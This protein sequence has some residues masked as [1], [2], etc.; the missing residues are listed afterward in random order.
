RVLKRDDIR[1]ALALCYNISFTLSYKIIQMGRNF[2]NGQRSISCARKSASRSTSVRL[3]RSPVVLEVFALVLSLLLLAS[4]G[5]ALS[6]SHSDLHL[7]PDCDLC[8]TLGSNSDMLPVVSTLA[9]L[10]L[11]QCHYQER[12]VVRSSEHVLP[13]RSRSPPAT[14]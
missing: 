5:T 3:K 9:A 8:L 1:P 2:L 11:P 10:S 13:A 6:H 4:Q 7:H 12:H 14:S